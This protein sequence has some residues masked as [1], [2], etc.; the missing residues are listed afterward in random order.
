M[1]AV[2]EVGR[3]GERLRRIA[4]G[5]QRARHE[6]LPDLGGKRSA[7]D[8]LAAELGQHRLQ[9]VRVANPHG[10]HELRR[11]A[12]EPRVA[13]V[14]RRPGLAG[15][16]SIGKRCAYAGARGHDT[17][18]DRSQR[19]R[20]G[21]RQSLACDR[22]VAMSRPRAHI[23]HLENDARVIAEDRTVHAAAVV[24][25]RRVGAG[26]I[27]R[28]DGEGAEADREER[29]EMAAHTQRVGH[30]HDVLR[31]GELCEL[32]VNG[33]VGVHQPVG[34]VRAAHVVA[35]VVRDVPVAV[36]CEDRHGLR[37]ERR[38]R[39]QALVQRGREHDRLE[40]RARL[41]LGLRREVELARA[42]VGAAEHRL[43][44]AVPRIDRDEGRCRAVR[45]R[46][47]LLDRGARDVL[48][49]EVDRRCHVQAAT[50]HAPRPVLRDKLILHVVDEV[51][52]QLALS[53]E[54]HILRPRQRLL[55]RMAQLRDG[56]LLLLDHHQQHLAAPRP[57][58]GRACHG[59]VGARVGGNPGEQRGLREIEVTR[60]D[61]EVRVRGLL[62]AVRA[63]SEVD[64]VQVRAQDLVLAPALRELPG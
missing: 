18:Q 4:Q 62:D 11:V 25:D 20:L 51:R 37:I 28:V 32:R 58:F 29:V 21:T 31:L 3:G 46:E 33:V 47:D 34:Q 9:L 24:R 57:R 60:A 13:V 2:A 56:D 53:G 61:S 42:E 10:Y 54:S 44:R 6:L 16:R 50:E 19:S 43:H 36:A 12:D 26:H 40:R 27:Q 63:V 45:V 8:R 52:R 7:C 14:V 39:R 48:Q 41:A 64:R 17:L 38:Q 55:V 15:D 22:R 49:A 59:V 1:L 23:L 5:S 30:R 35:L